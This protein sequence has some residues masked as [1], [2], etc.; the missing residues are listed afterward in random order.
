MTREV[1]KAVSDHPPMIIFE[2]L[3]LSFP[4]MIYILFADLFEKG[5][6]KFGRI[7]CAW[8]SDLPN[9]WSFSTFHKHEIRNNLSFVVYVRT[10]DDLVILNYNCMT[11]AIVLFKFANTCIVIFEI[12]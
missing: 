6:S 8:L 3:C 9:F 10:E 12:V 4:P 1:K 7:V 11:L 2:R 5:G